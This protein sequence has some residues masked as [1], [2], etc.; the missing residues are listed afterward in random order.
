MSKEAINF[1]GDPEQPGHVS[2]LKAINWL[3]SL[4][5]LITSGDRHVYAGYLLSTVATTFTSTPRAAHRVKYSY[6][7]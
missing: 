1:N 4:L 3:F 2:D 6:T 5:S 7:A